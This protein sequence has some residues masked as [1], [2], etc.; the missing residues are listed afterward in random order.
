MGFD[1]RE[2]EH[3]KG[4]INEFHCDEAMKD[5]FIELVDKVDALVSERDHWKDKYETLLDKLTEKEKP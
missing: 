3:L 4:L 2:V 1:T 5:L